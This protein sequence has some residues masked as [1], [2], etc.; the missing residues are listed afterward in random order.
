MRFLHWYNLLSWILLLGSGT[1][2]MA[3]PKFALFGTA[4]PKA[5][6]SLAG[7]AA[8]LLRLHAGWGLLWALIIVPFFL[9]FKKGG[10]EALKE[11]RLTQDD[12]RWLLIKPFAAM[13]MTSKPLPRQDKYNAGQKAFATS[14]LVGTATIIVSGLVM[15]FHLGP[16][17]L[18][19]AMILVHKMA[20][21]I[22]LM[23]L[24]VHVTMAAL[25]K[26][27]RPALSSMITGKVKREHAVLHAT[28]WAEELSE[29]DHSE[30]RSGQDG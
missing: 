2:L 20:I 29:E 18:M 4:M 5:I 1:A 11:I 17:G 6:A 13:G 12:I 19:S 22:A 24:A 8:N 27:E 30:H 16:A 15:T 28:N 3:T 26:D 10:I 23:G 25:V 7:G 14:A 21:A 9:M